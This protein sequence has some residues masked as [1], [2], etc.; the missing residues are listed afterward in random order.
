M[1]VSKIEIEKFDGKGDF[2][3]WKK[4]MCVVLVQ[5]KYAKTIGDPSDFPEMI[6]SS[7]KQEILENAYSLLILNLADN[8][9]CQ[10]DEE[11]TALKVWNKLDSLY[12]VKSLLNRIYLKEQL[13]GFKM[14]S[15]KNLEENLKDFKKIT[16]GLA[17]IN[18]KIS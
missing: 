5:Q 14:D 1:G 13:F 2:S 10:V 16:V 18:E 6:K 15:S 8:V 3:M 17:N 7:Y 11:D 9:F 4:K 12:M